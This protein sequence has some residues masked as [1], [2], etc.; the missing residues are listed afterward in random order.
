MGFGPGLSWTEKVRPAEN[1]D[2]TA[3]CPHVN[4]CNQIAEI[5]YLHKNMNRVVIAKQD[6]MHSAL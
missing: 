6:A 4:S 2:A 5:Y 1:G 3:L